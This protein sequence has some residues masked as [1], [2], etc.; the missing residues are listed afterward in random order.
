MARLHAEFDSPQYD[1]ETHL[2]PDAPAETHQLDTSGQ[3]FPA[4]P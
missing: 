2:L 3:V 1:N 4:P